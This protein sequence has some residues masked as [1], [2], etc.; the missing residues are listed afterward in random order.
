MKSRHFL[1][2]CGFLIFFGLTSI[3]Q[4][5]TT[6]KVRGVVTDKSGEPLPGVNVV[7]EG[8]MMG[9]ATDMV[10][11]YIITNIPPGSYNLAF[12]MIGYSKARVLGAKISIDLTTEINAT[13]EEEVLEGTEVVVTATR[14]IVQRDLTSAQATIS[15]EV[16]ENLPVQEVNQVLQLQ[17]GVLS[18][19]DGLHIR[20][21][22]A[23]EVAYYVDGVSVTDSY[24]NQPAIY[25]ENASVQELQVISGTFNAEYGQAMSGIVNIVTRDGGDKYE[26]NLN[27]Y[28]GDYVSNHEETFIHIDDVDPLAIQNYQGSLSGPVPLTGNKLHFF[29]TGRYFDT[30]GYIFGERRY[31]IDGTPGDSAVVPLGYET[32]KSGQ[33]KLSYNLTPGLKL[34]VSGFLSSGENNRDDNMNDFKFLP[35]ARKTKYDDGYSVSTQITHTL[36][37]TTFYTFNVSSFYKGY[38][39]YVFEDPTDSRYVSSDSLNQVPVYNVKNQ[40][41]ILGNFERNTTSLVGKFDLT[42]QVNKYNQVKFG[43]EYKKHKLFQEYITPVPAKDEYGEQALDSLGWVIEDISSQNHG[44]YTENPNEFS[45]YIQDKIEYQDVIINIGLR[46]DYFDAQSHVL[47][48]SSDP[49]IYNPLNPI[50]KAMTLAEREA[51]WWKDTEAKYR[52][53]PRFGIAY[54]ITDRG[55]IHFSYGHFLQI[56]SFSL[57]FDNPGFKVP[58]SSGVHGIYGNPDLEPQKTVMYEIGLQQ[59]IGTSLNLDITGFYRDIRDWV[60]VS[61][62]IPTVGAGG[63]E[64]SGRTYVMYMNRDYANVRGITLSLN[65]QVSR[66]INYSFDYT[67]QISENSNSRA[68]EEFSSRQNNDEPT[69]MITPADWDQAH[70]LNGSI[71]L[72]QGSWGTSLI[73][74]YGS[75]KPY[76]PS[77]TRAVRL[78]ANANLSFAQNSRRK[79]EEISFDFRAYKTFRLGN[80]KYIIQMDIYN[81]FDRMNEYNVYGDTGR[82]TTSSEFK[83]VEQAEASGGLLYN[84]AEEWLT[85]PGR[86][87][88]PREIHLGLQIDF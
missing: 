46:F 2:L 69:R 83:Q 16:I 15:S 7:V 84:T 62:P 64:L 79:P 30:D 24:N 82:A 77:I 63:Y 17:A 36:S 49:N 33:L 88:A 6:G 85:Q 34:R 53:S 38:E 78:G 74:R 47:A 32:K 23:S 20:G 9:A 86:F 28:V 54:P 72:G 3:L 81:L 58:A 10:G 25:V 73:G 21:G 40:G 12:T 67:F 42:S 57:L 31:N 14:P 70:T 4:A 52:I 1:L 66:L 61:A 13:M 8:T 48:D 65:Q 51:I 56:P 80:F 22:R 68:D 45:A 50:Y 26:G 41:T 35:D 19:A 43:F 44:R 76:T 27:M 59:Q 18:D 5:G 60:G 75:G 39:D 29:A 71:R 11:E 55:V 87:S 37:A